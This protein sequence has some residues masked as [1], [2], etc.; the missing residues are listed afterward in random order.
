[1]DTKQVQFLAIPV[2]YFFVKMS[3]N[4]YKIGQLSRLCGLTER[5]IRYYDE[6]GLLKTKSRTSGG[7]RVYSDSDLVYIKRIIELKALSFSLDEIKDIIR[8]GGE[9][10]S[11]EK[12]RAVLLQAYKEKKEAAEKKLARLE[13]EI[14]ELDWHIR[15]LEGSFNSFKDCPGRLCQGCAFRENCSFSED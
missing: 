9:D 1:M 14:S 8:L 6:L 4:H 13:E 11:G 3:E 5:T 2:L 15:Q 10:E 12:R 7:Q